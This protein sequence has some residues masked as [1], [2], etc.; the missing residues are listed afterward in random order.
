MFSFP[1][2]SP[3]PHQRSR[4]SPSQ[5]QRSTSSPDLIQRRLS[6][7]DLH[8]R[9]TASS[10]PHQLRTP[11][12]RLHTLEYA[13]CCTHFY[14]LSCLTTYPQNLF[15]SSSAKYS[16]ESGEPDENNMH[17]CP[18]TKTWNRRRDGYR[19]KSAAISRI[20]NL[21][22]TWRSGWEIALTSKSN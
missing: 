19:T 17:N 9:K 16:H 21:L 10:E 5:H 13:V 18:G 11:Q 7:S 4:A 15:S 2:L 14:R 22:K 6:S 20:E 8:Q 1:S 12:T 3:S